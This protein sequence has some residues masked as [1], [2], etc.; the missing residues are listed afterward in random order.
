MDEVL[1]QLYENGSGN[2]WDGSEGQTMQD[3]L[4]LAGLTEEDIKID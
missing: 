3:F 2:E 4:D 1:R